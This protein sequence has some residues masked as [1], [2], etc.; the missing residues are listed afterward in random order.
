MNGMGRRPSFIKRY[1]DLLGILHQSFNKGVSSLAVA[2]VRRLKKCSKVYLRVR[3]IL[4]FFDVL[5]MVN[6]G[7]RSMY[8]RLSHVF[9]L[10]S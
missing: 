3:K 10:A 5:L 2:S 8:K 7:C 1:I 4:S 6:G 9:G